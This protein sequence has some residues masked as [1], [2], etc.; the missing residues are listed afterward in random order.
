MGKE[1]QEKAMI[2]G[3][4]TYLKYN[5]G[6][7]DNTLRAYENDLRDFARFINVNYA[8]TSWRQVN[9]KMVDTFVRMLVDAG[10][11]PAS[12]KQ[13]V[14]SLRT[15]FKT[16]YAMGMEIGNPA[17]YVSTPKLEDNLPKAIPIDDIRATVH[18]ESIDWRARAIITVLT[19]TGIRIQELLDMQ[20]EDVNTESR[21][22]KIHGKGRKERTVY[23]GDGTEKWLEQWPWK[24]LDQRTV[25][26]L[27]YDALSQHSYA[28]QLSPHALRH[29]YATE[30]LNNGGRLETL[31]ALLGHQ[32]TKVTERYA[33][34]GTKARKTEYKSYMPSLGFAE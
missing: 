26:H 7:S 15:F 29:T 27:V 33:K 20:P 5:K 21:S 18:D 2:T 19:E 28:E 3:F 11:K 30:M 25:R 32:D 23:Y 13:H 1:K 31:S 8:G 6:Y 24:D 16:C 14:S 34:M 4:I 22:I 9:K 12:I 10:Q 17:K